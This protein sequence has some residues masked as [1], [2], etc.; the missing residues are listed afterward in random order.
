MALDI[1]QLRADTPGCEHV[2]HFNNAGAGLMPQPVL[3]AVHGHLVRE[4]LIGGYE[5]HHSADDAYRDT[6]AAIS[7]LIGAKSSEIA[8]LENATRAWDQVFYGMTFKPGDRVITAHASYASNYLAML[9]QRRRTG[10]KIDVIGNDEHGQVDTVELE[11]SITERTRLICLTHIPTNGGLINPAKEVGR[12]ARKHN[13]PYLLDACQSAGQTEVNVDRIG[14]DFLSSTGRK[15]LR[16]PR[17]TGFLYVRTESLDLI[18]PPFLD[19]HAADWVGRDEYRMADGAARFENWEGFVAGKIAL[20]AAVRYLLEL[21]PDEVYARIADVAA[22]LRSRLTDIPGIDVYD[23]GR[24]KGGI[25]T[26]SHESTDA[27]RIKAALDE[28]GMNTNLAIPKWARLDAEDRGLPTMIRASVHAYNTE[29]E[30][31]RFA[32]AVEHIVL[33]E[34]R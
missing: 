29:E 31:E 27:R 1:D 32:E 26:F 12:I 19:L 10:L 5:A 23:L 7:E 8:L 34:S 18:E 24:R 20:G 2:L 21:G 25:V 11:A 16:G 22:Q 13:V 3:D 33:T 9:Q 30:V 6:Y 28:R 15:Y 17:G 4:S 14:C